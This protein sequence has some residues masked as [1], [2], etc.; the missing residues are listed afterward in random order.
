MLSLFIEMAGIDHETTTTFMQESPTANSPS[1][2]PPAQL[3][4]RSA[5][6]GVG[7]NRSQLHQSSLEDAN[8]QC[9][10][11][12]VWRKRFNNKVSPT[13]HI[14]RKGQPQPVFANSS[15]S[16]GTTGS[17]VANRSSPSTIVIQDVE[18][19]DGLF[20][21]PKSRSSKYIMELQELPSLQQSCKPLK[22]RLKSRLAI[23]ISVSVIAIPF[24]MFRSND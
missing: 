8:R 22:E 15:S 5:S 1:T 24:F 7:I 14:I 3:M 20:Q 10:S 2:T 23:R 21:R 16:S 13:R 12:V 4:Q 9:T 11:D 18:V 19:V 6:D 17:D